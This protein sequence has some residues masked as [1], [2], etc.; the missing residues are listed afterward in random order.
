MR[1]MSF[2]GPQL[3]RLRE[4]AL[5][6]NR[7]FSICTGAFVL[8]KLFPFEKMTMT[9][10]WRH[11]SDLA[12]QYP[13]TRVTSEPLFIRDDNKW[14]SAGVLSGVDLALAIIRLDHGNVTAASVA[15]ELVV[16]AQ[17]A[18]S[19]NQFSDM[20]QVQSSESLKLVPLL[21]WLVENVHQQLTVSNMAEF[22]CLSERQLTRLFK[23]HLDSTPGNYFKR[24]KLHYARDLLS[25]ENTS[26]EQVA[27]KVGF[28]SYD[29]F[30]RAFQNHFS[31]SPSA[32]SKGINS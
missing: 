26:I 6:A 15:K 13:N 25:S 29:S 11:C 9:S 32:L 8:A 4:I 12:R 30:R 24:L 14:S 16:Y 5:D 2:S 3:K 20:L 19:Q 21:D 28:N 22:L 7:V 10:H 1:T 31:M 23:E 18:G 17:R 27:L